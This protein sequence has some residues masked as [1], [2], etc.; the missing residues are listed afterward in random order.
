VRK[1]DYL[2]TTQ[3]EFRHGKRFI[4]GKIADEQWLRDFQDRKVDIRPQDS[5]RAEVLIAVRYGHDDEV[6]GES[7]VI[8]RVIEVL[9]PGARQLPLLKSPDI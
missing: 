7:Y 1:P 9:P 5:I 6:V 8:E 3:W 4:D 2:G